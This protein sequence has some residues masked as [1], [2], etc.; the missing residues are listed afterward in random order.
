MTQRSC[1]IETSLLYPTK[2]TPIE[3]IDVGALRSLFAMLD[4]TATDIRIQNQDYILIDCGQI[5]V[6]IVSCAVPFPQD[7]F[8]GADFPKQDTVEGA[9]ICKHLAVH[10]S[11]LTVIVVD[12][13]IDA[14]HVP[15]PDLNRR[16][17]WHLMYLLMEATQ[18]ELVFWGEDDRLMTPEMATEAI[19]TF[20]RD[21][22]IDVNTKT[23]REPVEKP[24][25]FIDVAPE[26]SAV[27]PTPPS[28]Q[29]SQQPVL[30]SDALEWFH[31]PKSGSE[32]A[33]ANKNTV[34][35]ATTALPGLG[36]WLRRMSHVSRATVA[37]SALTITIGLCGLPYKA[38]AAL[39]KL[40]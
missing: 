27:L 40:F 11:S 8:L 6:A 10:A 32:Q 37:T 9:R 34:S 30:S 31:R 12:K 2:S 15:D 7:H 22:P 26:K 3:Q 14:S 36:N 16:I 24:Q 20:H 28:E 25:D 29:F 4:L 35:L 38:S 5:D 18:P 1:P 21:N 39:G 19:K 33:E 13:E 23:A 17:G